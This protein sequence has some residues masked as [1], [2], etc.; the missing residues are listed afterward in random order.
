MIDQKL[1]LNSYI[2]FLITRA[3]QVFAVVQQ[4]TC[5]LTAQDSPTIYNPEVWSSLHLPGRIASPTVQAKLPTSMTPIHHINFDFLH[6]QRTVTVMCA[7]YKI[8]QILT[9]LAHLNIISWP[10]DVYHQEGWEP[11]VYGTTTTFRFPSNLHT[12]PTWKHIVCSSS[13]I[14]GWACSGDGKFN[15]TKGIR[16]Q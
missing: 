13:L 9:R 7:I 6:Q 10:S 2:N 16:D 15:K 4:R 8:M 5:L 1:N 14:R 3:S 11:Q 12:I